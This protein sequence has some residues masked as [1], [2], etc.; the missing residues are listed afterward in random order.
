[1][2]YTKILNELTTVPYFSI[3][4]VDQ[5][6][7]VS[8]KA[9]YENINRWLKKGVLIQLKKGIYTTAEYYKTVQNKA[10]YLEFIANN[11]R[12]PSY[13]STEY[14]LQKYGVL[15]EQVFAFTSITT[16]VKRVYT[17]PLGTFVYRQVSKN[18][19]TGFKPVKRG[20]FTIYEAT[21]AKALFD[22]LYLKFR[23]YKSITKENIRDLRFNAE[24]FTKNDKKEFK[25]YCKMVNS[26]FE[27]LYNLI[28]SNDA[29]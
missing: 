20:D 15:A 29:S 6:L 14:I 8:R 19:F 3:E 22:F 16:K 17:N 11:L 25:T 26:K 7:N 10:A 5:L 24:T 23:N 21:K 12:T 28:F 13:L 9:L 2:K 4:T 1:M 27:S 18:L